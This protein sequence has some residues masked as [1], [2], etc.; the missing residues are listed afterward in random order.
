[1]FSEMFRY[2]KKPE[3]DEKKKIEIKM[4][5]LCCKELV[6]PC[7]YSSPVNS[8]KI[9]KTTNGRKNYSKQLIRGDN[10]APP[11]KNFSFSKT[12]AYGQR[13]NFNITMVAPSVPV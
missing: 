13:F 4:S 1:M 3:K 8:V 2:E 6:F 7:I 12:I 9:V 11:V 5:R 10:Q